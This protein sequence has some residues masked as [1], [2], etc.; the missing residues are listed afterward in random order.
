MRARRR[1]AC[2]ARGCGSR[3]P[4]PRIR[5]RIRGIE[6]AQRTERRRLDHQACAGAIADLAHENAY[7]PRRI[8]PTARSFPRCHPASRRQPASCGP[9]GN[10]SSRRRGRREAR[11]PRWTAAGGRLLR[12]AGRQRG[13]D[14][15]VGRS[16]AARLRVRARGRLLLRRMPDGRVGDVSRAGWIRSRVCARVLRGLG[17]LLPHPRA[18]QARLRRARRSGHAR[19]QRDDARGGRRQARARRGQPGALRRALGRDAGRGRRG[20]RDRHLPA[21]VPPDPRERPLVGPG[22][23]RMDE[24]RARDAAVSRATASR[25]FPATSGFYDLR[26]RRGARG[27]GGARR[28]RTGIHGF[29]YYYYWFNGQPAARAAARRHARRG[30]PDFP[31][32]SAG[33]TRTGRAAGTGSNPRC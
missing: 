25:T 10:T 6:S 5:G 8:S 7:R 26:A 15:A 3:G 16:G 28:A 18:R 2:R 12:E 14:R 17:P 11:V 13:D 24:R 9:S 19:A 30:D 29:C 4:S 1:R 23:H 31:S 32:A 22:L 21:A 33:R 27:A 20:P